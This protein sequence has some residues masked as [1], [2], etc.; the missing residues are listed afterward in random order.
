MLPVPS[1]SRR[2]IS[3]CS[4]KHLQRPV[5]LLGRARHL[6]YVVQ[7]HIEVAGGLRVDRIGLEQLPRNLQL[8]LGHL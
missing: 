5:H 1:S 3:N 7:R 2:A 8:L 6:T 4:L